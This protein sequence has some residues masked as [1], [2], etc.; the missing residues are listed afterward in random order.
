M[1]HH[2]NAC[3]STCSVAH[4]SLDGSKG[5]RQYYLGC[6]LA[7]LNSSIF[8]KHILLLHNIAILAVTPTV[9]DVDI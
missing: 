7:L 4:S 9:S 1:L 5:L 6:T 3:S 8:I 2:S